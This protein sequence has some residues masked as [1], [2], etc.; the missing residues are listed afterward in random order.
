MGTTKEN[1]M[2]LV[3]PD[4]SDISEE[5]VPGDYNCVVKKAELKDWP[6]G[7]KY[8]NWSL[9]TYGSPEQ[10]NNGRYIFHKTST[11]GKSA[12]H[13]QKLYKAA[14]GENLAGAFDTDQLL[15]RKVAVTVVAGMRNGQPTGYNEVKTVRPAQA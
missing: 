1:K 3:Q 8:I 10:K 12:F 11:T 7:S 5:I 9:E 4:F 6:D 2:A 15:G 14:T 13:L